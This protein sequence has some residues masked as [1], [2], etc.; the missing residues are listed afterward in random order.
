M[1]QGSG[2]VLTS[3][4]VAVVAAFADAAVVVAAVVA[5]VAVVVA[6]V[7]AAVAAAVVAAV[8]EFAEGVDAVDL[9]DQSHA[10]SARA[11]DR[12]AGPP[13]YAGLT[14]P[15]TAVSGA[16]PGQGPLPPS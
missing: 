16:P 2:A 6:A 4:D 11:K 1:V 5:V 15:L 3:S 13:S 12:V 9:D 10:A 8:D 14:L 7:A